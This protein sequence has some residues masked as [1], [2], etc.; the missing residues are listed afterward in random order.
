[1]AARK[2]VGEIT[3]LIP[4]N[5]K[6][7]GWYWLSINPEDDVLFQSVTGEM[8]ACWKADSERWVVEG[9]WISPSAMSQHGYK[10]SSKVP[11]SEEFAAMQAQLQTHE[12]E[13][14]SIDKQLDELTAKI[15]KLLE[16]VR[17]S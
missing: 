6:E 14:K 3:R 17:G 13:R 7:D 9:K 4:K 12:R 2:K 16:V 10:I 15:D 8:P 5:K 1:M 11:S